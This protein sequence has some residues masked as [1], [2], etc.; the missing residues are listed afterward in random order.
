[1]RRALLALS[2]LACS[3]HHVAPADVAPLE[4]APPEVQPIVMTAPV[5]P[6]V[7]AVDAG[8]DAS[9]LDVD[10]GVDASDVDVADAAP[11]EIVDS[12][13]PDQPDTYVPPPPPPVDAAPAPKNV[14][15]IDNGPNAGYEASCRT[16]QSVALYWSWAYSYANGDGACQNGSWCQCGGLG[17]DCP[18]GAPCSM[19]NRQ[20][21][22]NWGHCL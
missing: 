3:A 21:G 1:M 5:L 16:D 8:V 7:V 12:A 6:P 22:Q 15:H 17:I 9:A 10:A 19:F 14:C 11:I 18:V 2:L 20:N 13:T 4:D